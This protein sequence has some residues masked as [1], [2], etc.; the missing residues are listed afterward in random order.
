M[1]TSVFIAKILGPCFLVVAVGIMRN[2]DF[3]QKVME[4]YCKN[5]SLVFFGGVLALVIGLVVVLNHIVWEMSWR[6]MITIYGWGGIIKGIWLVV[7]PNTVP[8]FIQAYA[9]NKALL[10]AHSVL[11]L[12]FGVV[13]TVF[14]YFSG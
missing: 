13:F 9:K 3:Y 7:F 14:G 12:I 5:A 10:L 6:V 1:D 2:R 11:V 8:R 4:D